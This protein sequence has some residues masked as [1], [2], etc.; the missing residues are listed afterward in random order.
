MTIFWIFGWHAY[1]FLATPSCLESIYRQVAAPWQWT[2]IHRKFPI[3]PLRIP[4]KTPM[5]DP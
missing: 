2:L 4:Y 5:E 3:N 1:R